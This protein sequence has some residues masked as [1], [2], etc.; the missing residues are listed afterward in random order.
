MKMDKEW[1]L[2]HRFWLL[3]GTFGLLW[4]V[5]LTAL[6]VFGG[7]PIEAAK[8]AVTDAD[9]VIKPY[10]AN[11]GPNRPKN[12]YF[13][14]KWKEYGT[15]FRNHKNTVW[16]IAWYGDE[17]KPDDPPGKVLW[18][19]QGGMY[20]WPTTERLDN[21]VLV[22]GDHPLNQVL[23]SPSVPFEAGLRQWYKGSD[24]PRP[25]GTSSTPCTTS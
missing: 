20:T 2:K 22:A 24:I 12:D 19:G 4:F 14:P 1:A 7:G 25:T 9:G 21:G 6:L 23:L 17:P 15:T 11:S 13:L 10:T 8:K 3:L 18:K 16:K 5:C